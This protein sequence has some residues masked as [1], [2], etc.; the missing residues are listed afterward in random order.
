MP[1]WGHGGPQGEAPVSGR[2]KAEQEE[3]LGESLDCGF[4]RGK[5]G[6]A[7]CAG[8]T[9]GKFESFH[10][11]LASLGAVP[12]CVVPSP[13]VIRTEAQWV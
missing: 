10:Q 4:H 13:G 12:G 9:T 8:L 2:K 5:A 6:Q 1:C 7:G 11:A 3:S